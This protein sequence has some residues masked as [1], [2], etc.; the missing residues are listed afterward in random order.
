VWIL[1]GG[2]SGLWFAEV[3]LPSNNSAEESTK[4]DEML[5]EMVC[6]CGSF[7]ADG[8]SPWF[9]SGF[10]SFLGVRMYFT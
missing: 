8:R 4:Q 2:L 1:V 10:F 7:V 6:S 3:R 5:Y 9:T